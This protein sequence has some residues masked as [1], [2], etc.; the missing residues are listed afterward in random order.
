MSFK[1]YNEMAIHNGIETGNVSTGK[2]DWNYY[3]GEG[4]RFIE[5]VIDNYTPKK[6]RVFKT[7]STYF[8]IKDNEYIGHIEYDLKNGVATINAPGSTLKGGFYNLIFTAMFLD[9]VKEILSNGSLSKKAEKSYNNLSSHF[10]VMIKDGSNYTKL[11]KENLFDDNI[12]T[13][14]SV[15]ESKIGLI[16]DLYNHMEQRMKF[17]HEGNRKSS[18]SASFENDDGIYEQYL[19]PEVW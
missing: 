3:K 4:S 10:K 9:G 11:S 5:L 16:T 6:Y 19:F 18:L 14:I 2:T 15:K 7:K 8:L 12:T 17:I 13:V 1:K